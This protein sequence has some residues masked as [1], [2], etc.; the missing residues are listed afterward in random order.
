MF[1]IVNFHNLRR[2][3]SLTHPFLQLS[4]TISTYM[5]QPTVIIGNCRASLVP[6]V[7]SS[8]ARDTLR[9]THSTSHH[10]MSS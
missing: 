8:Y 7:A 4:R 1:Y 2:I 6:G 10:P 3:N 9:I 5:L